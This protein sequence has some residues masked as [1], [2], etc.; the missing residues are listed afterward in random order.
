MHLLLLLSVVVFYGV[1]TDGL[2]SIVTTGRSQSPTPSTYYATSGQHLSTR[3]AHSGVSAADIQASILRTLRSGNYDPNSP[4][5]VVTNK[6]TPILVRL[7]IHRMVWF[8]NQVEVHITLKEQWHDQRLQTNSRIPV[9]FPIPDDTKIWEPDTYFSNGVEK[10]LGDKLFRIVE[11]SGYIRTNRMIS[12]KVPFKEESRFP[13]INRKKFRLRLSSYRY[14]TNDVIYQWP[15]TFVPVELA[16]QVLSDRYKN[17]SYEIQ[18]CTKKYSPDTHS[19]LE[20]NLTF[21]GPVKQGIFKVFLPSLLL[22]FASWLHFWI[23]G[24]W[25]VP[26]TLS[27]AGPFFVFAIMLLF[28]PNLYED[29]AKETRTWFVTCLIFTFISF[30]EYFLVICCGSRRTL[31]YTN[32][33]LE[34]EHMGKEAPDSRQTMIRADSSLDIVSRL[35]FPLLFFIFLTI[36]LLVQFL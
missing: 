8:E 9:A 18:D 12:V 4:P 1:S 11:E 24:S 36:Y 7:L 13:F 15:P 30:A 17:E 20:I 26:R 34:Q 14:S 16:D 6:G 21:V 27:A 2:P 31:R 3:R 10:K 19:C 33:I 5:S 22:V 35:A 29:Y 28:F 23:N 32:G 25:S